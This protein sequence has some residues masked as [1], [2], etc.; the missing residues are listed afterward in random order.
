MKVGWRSLRTMWTKWRRCHRAKK[1]LLL[2]ALFFL[3]LTRMAIVVLPFRWLAKSL[4]QYMRDN[5]DEL[6]P[7]ELSL[8][9][10][11]GGAIHS[12]ARYTPWN[13]TC[14]TRAVAAKWMLTYHNLPGIVYF[15]VAADKN[16]PHTLTA[17]AWTRSGNVVL[18]EVHPASATHNLQKYTIVAIFS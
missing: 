15:G 12:A 1:K 6:L 13:S 9:K 5:Y 17:H 10:M 16:N 8:T 11:I 18:T 14:M 4:G 3:C 7:N 2:E